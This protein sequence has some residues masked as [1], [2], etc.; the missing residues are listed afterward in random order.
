MRHRGGGSLELGLVFGESLF[1]IP[2]VQFI[3]ELTGVAALAEQA[4]DRAA[5]AQG[6]AQGL[7][8]IAA[9]AIGEHAG[10]KLVVR[11]A[12]FGSQRFDNSG[13]GASAAASVGVEGLV[14]GFQHFLG[15]QLFPLPGPGRRA[16]GFIGSGGVQA[17]RQHRNGG[18][19]QQAL[20]GSAQKVAATLVHVH[21]MSPSI[22]FCDCL[23][24]SA[25][26]QWQL[27]YD[28]TY[29]GACQPNQ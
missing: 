8:A 22:L 29:G 6:A 4:K 13:E 28:N 3:A 20:A 1:L 7:L 18:N 12:K 17:N 25:L 16:D 2:G 27:V 26:Y 23:L 15:I 19:A 5:A 14:A 24:Y 21:R 10:V 11:I 9:S